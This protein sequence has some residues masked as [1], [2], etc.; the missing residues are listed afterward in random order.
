VEARIGIGSVLREIFATYAARWRVLLA[1]AL[2]VELVL[3]AVPVLLA[4]PFGAGSPFT[5]LDLPVY[6]IGWA[7]YTAWVTALMRGRAGSEPSWASPFAQLRPVLLRIAAAGVLGALGI[8]CGLV[9]F[10]AP[11]L[12]AMTIWAVVVPAIVVER[13]SIVDAFRRS[14]ALVRGNRWRVLAVIL[15]CGVLGLGL[16]AGI[17]FAV[18]TGHPILRLAVGWLLSS[19]TAPLLSLPAPVLYFRLSQFEVELAVSAP[20]GLK[21]R[22]H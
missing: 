3:E 20:T 5:L 6:A 22:T 2:G 19:A 9:L 14:N 17:V 16:S 21:A 8:L 7:F 1:V 12:Y 10:L 4:Q 18:R 15:L 13:Q 11:G